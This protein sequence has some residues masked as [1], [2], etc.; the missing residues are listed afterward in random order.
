MEA[1]VLQEEVGSVFSSI[2]AGNHSFDVT[3]RPR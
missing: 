2:D 3:E 1:Q